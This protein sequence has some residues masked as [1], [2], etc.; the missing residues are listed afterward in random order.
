MDP[1]EIARIVQEL[2]ETAV[3]DEV[4]VTLPTD[5]D[6]IG[7][8]KLNRSLV[9]K[10]FDTR[11]PNRDTLRIQLPKILMTR[12]G[13]DVEIIGDN[14]FLVTFASS[15]DLRRTLSDGPWHYFQ[16]LMLFKAPQG[17]Q[18]P[19]D[20]IFDE[21]VIWVQCHNLPIK[22]M[23]PPT[24]RRI[25]EQVGRVVEVDIGEGGGCVGRFARVRVARPIEKPLQ[26]CVNITIEG[27]HECA[28]VLL[29]YEKLPE[30]CYACGRVGHVLSYCMDKEA[31]KEKLLY[32]SWLKANKVQDVKRTKR[33]NE[34]KD[35]RGHQGG[36]N[37]L[38]DTSGTDTA[39]LRD[40]QMED[41][42]GQ[43]PIQKTHRDTSPI[44]SEKKWK[45]KAR[46]VGEA[47]K[48]EQSRPIMHTTK[49]TTPREE[50]RQTE[51]LEKRH[52]PNHDEST[53]RH[54]KVQKLTA[55]AAQQLRRDQ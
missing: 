9:G 33:Q 38:E 53:S 4:V 34:S 54:Q 17:L 51:L 35:P 10:I 48:I 46:E 22:C 44:T 16:S 25:G 2:K 41:N 14:L 15:D 19:A 18:N 8:E 1:A 26:R 7:Q 27:S 24:V 23:H 47:K 11:A 13:I 43:A 28:L 30:F 55:E 6:Q 42:H 40:E 52:K 21:L 32:G 37:V 49:R 3:A 12:R 31:N 29:V 50:S 20:I 5:F 45:R 36:V 39:P